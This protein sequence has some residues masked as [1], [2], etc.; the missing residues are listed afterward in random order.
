MNLHAT[1]NYLLHEKWDGGLRGCD[2]IDGSGNALCVDLAACFEEEQSGHFYFRETFRNIFSH[3][4]VFTQKPA[5]GSTAVSS[6]AR[7]FQGTLG[8]TQ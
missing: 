2:H 8:G 1:V 4:L 3:A 7:K 6:L 5:K